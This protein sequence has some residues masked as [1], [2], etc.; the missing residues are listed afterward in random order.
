[1]GS[2]NH[3]HVVG[4]SAPFELQSEV[5]PLMHAE[6]AYTACTGKMA[7]EKCWEMVSGW[8]CWYRLGVNPLVHSGFKRKLFICMKG[9]QTQP[10]LSTVNQ[11]CGRSQGIFCSWY[12]I[13]T[14]GLIFMDGF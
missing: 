1:M 13:Q 14:I 5:I 12:Y 6:V 3:A 9:T 11:S 2:L 7:K 8:S 10:S 4:S